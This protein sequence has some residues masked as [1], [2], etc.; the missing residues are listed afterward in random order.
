MPH[1]GSRW[2]QG[3][4]SLG[5]EPTTPLPPPGVRKGEKPRALGC[6]CPPFPGPPRPW[7]VAP[8]RRAPEP[9][10]EHS[11][12]GRF[13]AHF[14]PTALCS[15]DVTIDWMCIDSGQLMCDSWSLRPRGFTPAPPSLCEWNLIA[16]LAGGLWLRRT[17]PCLPCRTRARLRP[18]IPSKTL[19]MEAW[20]QS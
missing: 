15:R 17:C 18:Q 4:R 13:Q 3:G 12:E 7:E 11:T 16:A 5:Q 19:Q 14:S 1:L 6:E 8:N 2:L 20:A 9:R 10:Y